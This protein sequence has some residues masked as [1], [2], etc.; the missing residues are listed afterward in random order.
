MPDQISPILTMNCRRGGGPWSRRKR[1]GQENLSCSWKRMC[2]WARRESHCV[3]ALKRLRKFIWLPDDAPCACARAR[4]TW[5]MCGELFTRVITFDMMMQL[6]LLF[7]C[8]LDRW[9]LLESECWH[10]SMTVR[11]FRATTWV[12]VMINLDRWNILVK[13]LAVLAQL[14][15]FLLVLEESTRFER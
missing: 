9:M 4:L 15:Y 8:N 3:E 1:R 13:K 6:D 11:S 12:M 2:E 5:F 14:I 7:I 10:G